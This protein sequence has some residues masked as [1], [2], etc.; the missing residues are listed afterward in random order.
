DHTLTQ[1]REWSDRGVELRVAV[2]LSVRNLYDRELV[3]WL[4]ERLIEHGVTASLLKL[5]I[6]E[7]Q[8]MDDPMVAM[9]VLGKMKS[10]GVSTSIDDFGPGYSSLAYLKNLPIDELKIDRSFVGNMVSHDHDLT[11]VR[12]TIDLSHNLGLG[13]VAEGVEDPETLQLLADMGC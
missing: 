5:E 12:S 11:I 4:S 2:N 13:V 9:E 10:L 8:L 7:S 1:I 6:T 3:P